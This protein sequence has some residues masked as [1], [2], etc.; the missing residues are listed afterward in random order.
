[1][2]SE[3]I[4]QS[5]NEHMHAELYAS[6]VYLA[7]AAYCESINLTGAGNWMR[8]Q[9]DE[10]RGHAMRFYRFIIDRGGRVKFGA[11]DDPP[12][13]FGSAL[14]VFE[15]TLKHEQAVTERIR[16]LYQLTDDENDYA[17]QT[18]LQW[19]VN[20]QVEEEKSAAQIVDD[21][22]MIGDD[23]PALLILDRELGARQPDKE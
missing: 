2:L 20:E 18:F 19:F 15:Y 21:L 8:M 14:E 1:M 13:A 4:E 9:S 23:K 5:L 11:I 16:K 3:R 22:R 7:L 6:H 10:E 12:D 17:T